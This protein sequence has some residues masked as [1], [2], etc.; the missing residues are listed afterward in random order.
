MRRTGTLY[1]DPYRLFPRS[2]KEYLDTLTKFLDADQIENPEFFRLNA[3]KV[4]Y[5]QLF[6]ASLPFDQ[7]LEDDGVWRGYVRLKKF[8]FEQV[9]PEKSSTIQV[10]LDG[11]LN[12]QPFIRDL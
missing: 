10:V 4:L 9:S 8:S 1:I 11:I 5:S 12:Q 6:R 2:R 3:R 7:F